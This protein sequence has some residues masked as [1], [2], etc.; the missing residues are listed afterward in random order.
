MP[1]RAKSYSP[2][3]K[4]EG[5]GRKFNGRKAIDQ[6]Y[7][8]TWESYRR[9]FLAINTRCYACGQAATVVDHVRPHKGSK[10]LF[11][12]TDNHISLCKSDHDRVTTLFDRKFR[13]GN[14]IDPKLRW[15]AHKRDSLGLT[16]R[17]KVLPEYP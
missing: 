16:F 17:I 5:T 3:H 12:K 9:K 2:R 6:M 4:R 7:D 15:L 1:K 13:E 8:S 11:E 10:T 14:S